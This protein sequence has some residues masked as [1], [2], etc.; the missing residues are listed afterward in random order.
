MP[1]AVLARRALIV[2][3]A[4]AMLFVASAAAAPRAVR[5]ASPGAGMKA[6][7]IVGPTHSLTS[8]NLSRGEAI[9]QKAESYGMDVRRVFHPKATWARVLNNIQ[10]AHLVAYLGHG[11]GWPSP[12]GPFQENTK[13]GFGLNTVEGGSASDVTYYGANKIRNNIVL[14]ANAVVL[15]SHLCYASGN[16]EPGMA[17]P[18]WDVARQRV[19]NFAAGFLYVGARAVFAYGTGTVVP[20]VD[21]LFTT[22]KTMDEIFMTPGAK[23]QAH[24]GFVGWDNRRFDSERMPGFRNHLDPDPDKG[25]LRALTGKLAMSSATWRDGGTTDSGTLAKPTVDAPTATFVAGPK[26]SA[27][28]TVQLTWPASASPNVVAYDLQYSR[29]GGTWTAVTLPSSGSTS[30]RVALPAGSIYRFRLRARDG[31]GTV[32]DWVVTTDRKLV[33]KQ[34]KSLAVTYQGTWRRVS[35]SGASG[36]YVSKSGVGGSGASHTFNG[37]GVA[38]VSTRGANRG[39]AEVWLDGVKVATVDLYASS[40]LP[41]RVVWASERLSA[42]THTIQVRVT[43]TKNN[44]SSSFRVDVDAFLTWR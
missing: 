9:A 17:I 22:D 41:A 30:A 42:A 34:E 7:I 23:P 37:T 33:R 24:Y 39:I 13:N 25:F 14:A 38:L 12:Y 36:G 32:G 11:N 15:L 8:T 28:V 19:D 18:G 1:G 29:D 26:A 21:A 16:G 31:A 5:A 4:V 44:A 20:V 43:G 6:V 40:L 35:L 3:I 10:G 27:K 2:L